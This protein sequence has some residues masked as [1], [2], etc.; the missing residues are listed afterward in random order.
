M[1]MFISSKSSDL[2]NVVNHHQNQEL[3]DGDQTNAKKY[4]KSKL[5]SALL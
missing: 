5:I 4:N 2:E 3:H 1:G